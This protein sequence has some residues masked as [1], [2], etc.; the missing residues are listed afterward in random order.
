MVRPYYGHRNFYSN[1]TRM[2]TLFYHYHP[3]IMSHWIRL[4]LQQKHL[5][6]E[7]I[8]AVTMKNTV[9]LSVKLCSLTDCLLCLILMFGVADASEK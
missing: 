7:I 9:C 3:I 5:R 6:F 1:K 4:V 8:I 2:T